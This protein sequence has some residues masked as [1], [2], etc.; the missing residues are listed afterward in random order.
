MGRDL[1]DNMPHPNESSFVTQ[2]ENKLAELPADACVTHPS[3]KVGR[4]GRPVNRPFLML[5]PCFSAGNVGVKVFFQPVL[6]LEK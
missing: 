5:G 4:A 1:R 6:V 2:T 3:T